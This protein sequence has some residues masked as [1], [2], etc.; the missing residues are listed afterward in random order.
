MRIAFDMSS[1]L[2]TCLLAG[3]DKENGREVLFQEKKVWINSADY[4]YELIISS[5]KRVINYANA[6][7]KD[8]ILVWEGMNSK[9]KRLLINREYKASRDTRPPEAYA[10]FEKLQARLEGVFLDLG[11]ICMA[12]DYA[13]G[14]DTLA[15]LAKHTEE[16]LLIATF[17]NDLAALNG[18][19]AYGAEITTW[20]DRLIGVNKFGVFD[21]S[22]ITT[23]KALVGDTSDNIKGCPGFG[24]AAFAKL[25]DKYGE[26]GLEELQAA[27]LQGSLD[28]FHAYAE[29]C[30]LLK[31]ICSHEEEVKT[32]FEL[33][34]LRPEWVDTMKS[35]IQIQ[36]GMTRQYQE[37]DDERLSKWYGR[38]R[39]VTADNFKVACDWARQLILETPEPTLDIET[40][41]N[42]ESDEWLSRQ[43]S[44]DENTV[45]MLGS[46]LT[47]M[48]LTF[49]D[50][51][52]YSLYFS[53]DHAETNNIKSEDLRDF[54]GS[55]DKPW[56][57]H[58]TY[59]ELTVLWN[60]WSEAWKDNG[61]KGF[62]KSVRDTLF[63]AS[64]VN[65]NGPLGLKSLSFDILCYQ[66][67]TYEEVTTM[68]GIA[69]SLLPGGRLV[70][71][72]DFGEHGVKETRRYK[73]N[74]LSGKHVLKYGLDDTICT[75]A[76]HNYCKLVMQLEHTYA[77]YLA[78]EI[79]AAYLHA[80]SFITGL[81]ISLQKLNALSAEDTETYDSAWIVVRKYLI[82]HGWEGTVCPTY[83]KNITPAQVKEAFEIVTS[84]KLDTL[85]RTMSKLVTFC[86]VNEGEELFARCLE[87]LL[88][89]ED[90]PLNNQIALHFKG[91][92]ENPVGSAKKMGHLM[93]DVMQ[94]PV[95]VRN[96]PT[97]NMRMRGELGSAK[98]DALA[99]AYALQDA[100]EEDKGCLEALKLMQ[101][102]KTRRGLYYKSYPGFIHWKDGKIH[103]SHRQCS[104]NTRR[105][106]SARPN[107]QQMPKHQKIEGQ[108]AKF[109]EVVVPHKKNAVIVSMD[110][111][112]QEMV[113]IAE[114]SQDGAL[115]SCYVGDNKRKMHTLT[116]LGIMQLD[117]RTLKSLQITKADD[118]EWTYSY[119]EEARKDED[120]ADYYAATRGYD[121]GKKVNFT[122]E[123][124]AMAPKLAQTMMVSEPLAQNFL[125][126][127]EAMFPRVAEWKL[128]I[129]KQAKQD[130]YVRSMCGAVR[131]L[132]E[133]FTGTDRWVASKAERQSVNYK[134]QG[135]AAEQT[136][137]A[138]GRMW[139]TKLFHRFDANYI[140][141]I[142][143]EAVAS[144][145]IADLYEFIPEMHA[146]MVANY[147]G[148]KVPTLSS[149]SFG[150]DFYN[151]IEIGKEP[152]REAIAAGIEELYE[153][154]KAA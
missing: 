22:L 10:E 14:D 95:K 109:R 97:D 87:K 62:L 138:E 28:E 141:P 34:R 92:P 11:A 53:V 125:D 58:N 16:T 115:L 136:K 48:G 6:A 9:S 1:F 77:V 31:K 12:Q 27:L 73:M 65:E 94:L 153:K 35:P 149:I 133:A 128:E 91:E 96:K 24:P 135:S 54:I 154:R 102:V 150:W 5:L 17:D 143:D 122:S 146:C 107:T 121:L 130:G 89:G 8:C 131:H 64:Y 145:A 66:Q 85:M 83:D 41:N 30:N 80:W 84:R 142:H 106:S 75:A 50:N 111:E 144:V 56:V 88:E 59:F 37:G 52:Q 117:M 124:G 93:Y 4:G 57:I 25:I 2:W 49:G 44:S 32:S 23:Y 74:E 78:V 108:D 90:Q 132:R 42:E 71:K 61:Q 103:S 112:G 60:E 148:M 116:G 20:V 13:E 46:K 36:V 72:E 39:L 18:T 127:R 40:S 67:T 81:D 86:R 151:Q 76:L 129:I 137:L 99:I 69:G 123:F 126:A 21:Y 110:F 79:D 29:D 101:M 82:E 55:F 33:A 45:D 114:Y 134:V 152:T 119:M 100:N 3:K 26:D 38:S 47:G 98:T 105:A 70:E 140:G 147:A 113:I 7:P 68:T 104:T 139:Q 120:H 19:N 118:R 15:W 63:E 51:N 43:E